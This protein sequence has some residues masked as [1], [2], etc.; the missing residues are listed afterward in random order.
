MKP[1]WRRLL[2]KRSVLN[3]I[4]IAIDCDILDPA[5]L[6]I[7][8]ELVREGIWVWIDRTWLPLIAVLPM[9]GG[10]IKPR[11]GLNAD[12]YQLTPKGI[13]LCDANNIERH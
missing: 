13:E 6:L 8:S 3:K 4:A 11:I 12:I 10:D 7:V 5:D 2:E 9:P 1:E